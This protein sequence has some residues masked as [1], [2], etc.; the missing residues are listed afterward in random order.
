ML[1]YIT[2]IRDALIE[3]SDWAAW[4]RRRLA[5]DEITL[6]DDSLVLHG[7]A[8]VGRYALIERD[9]ASERHGGA[10]WFPRDSRP[11]VGDVAGFFSWTH[12]ADE[13]IAMARLVP[14]LLRSGRGVVARPGN[15][16]FHEPVVR[17]RFPLRDLLERHGFDDGDALL[18]RDG[19]YLRDALD[20]IRRVLAA[21][22]LEA[23]VG[24]SGSHHNPLGIVGD[25]RRGGV[26]LRDPAGE[27]ERLSVELWA[28]DWRVLDDTAFWID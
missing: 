23:D 12:A 7:D 15:G 6:G 9:V 21:A 3:G 19:A 16:R 28:F 20:E 25:L 26:A 4:L 11:W 17:R 8:V 24:A 2:A 22:G 10:P 18:A 1:T 14:S 13:G 27:L 5:E